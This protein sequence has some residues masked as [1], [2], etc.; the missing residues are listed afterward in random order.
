MAI[1]NSEVIL[2]IAAEIESVLNEHPIAIANPSIPKRIGFLATRL[3]GVD[4]YAAGKAHKI[5][6]L[7][8]IFYSDRKHKKYAGGAEALW[9]EMTFGLLNVIKSHAHLRKEHGD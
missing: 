6:Q 5:A 9:S 8:E 1:K 3:N 2:K 4:N 7:A